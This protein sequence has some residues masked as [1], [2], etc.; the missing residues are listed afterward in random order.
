MAEAIG[1]PEDGVSPIVKSTLGTF[2]LREEF[3]GG[4]KM[5][6]SVIQRKQAVRYDA[7]LCP[8]CLEVALWR[9][10]GQSRL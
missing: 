10:P 5:E 2:S 4:G 1:D 7:Q 9:G 3:L 6:Y 8:S